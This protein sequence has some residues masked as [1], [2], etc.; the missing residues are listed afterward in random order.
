MSKY[1]EENPFKLTSKQLKFCEAYLF[2][3]DCRFN[4][5][6][7]AKLA[8]YSER[9]ARQ[10]ASQMLTNLN[11]QKQLGYLEDKFK[12]EL[13]KRTPAD[14]AE[15][16]SK[17]ISKQYEMEYGKVDIVKAVELQLKL[18][19]KLQGTGVRITRPGADNEDEHIEVSSETQLVMIMP[20]ERPLIIPPELQ[21]QDK[22]SP[23]PEVKKEK[24]NP[25]KEAIKQSLK[26][27][28]PKK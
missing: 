3:E 1:T 12:Q 19:H 4:A 13:Q 26:K 17:I 18:E 7:S 10:L 5:T 21:E 11:I 27:K 23:K 25:V 24:T 20:N 16:L 14:A 15:I 6:A 8:G 9:S 28:G 2:H 22:P